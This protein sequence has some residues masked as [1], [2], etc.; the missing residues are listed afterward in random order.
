MKVIQ[1][2]EAKKPAVVEMAKPE[3]KTGEALIKVRAVGICG[4]DIT[5][6]HGTN[7]NV[8][9]Y[10][11]VIG[12]ETVG[13]IAEIPEGNEFGL[14]VGDA[15]ILDPYIYCGTCYPCS[16][17]KTNCCESMQCLGVHCEGSMSEYVAHPMKL[18]RKLPE[19]LS[20]ELAPMAEPLVIAMHS[21]HTSKVVA[22][23]KVAIIGAGTIG[24]LAAMG[25]MAYG[26]EPIVID[27]IEERLALARECGVKYTIN[28]KT[29][30][31][32]EKLM[33]I[34][35]GRGAEVVVEASGSNVGIRNTL[36]YAAYTGRVALTGWPK[37][38]TT[39]P[40]NIITKKELKVLG[41]RNGAGEF[42][43]ALELIASGKVDAGKLITKT[44]AF[45]DLPSYIEKIAQN[46]SDFL[47]VIGSLGE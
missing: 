23:E 31:D 45:E 3:A 5:T 4:T 15:V 12:H 44:V 41:S 22:G 16:Q 43:E 25:A 8:K 32:V 10:P 17:G 33:E 2:Q 6:Y 37:Q 24:L 47:K 40:T 36:D 1:M 27:V 30:N 11:I 39:L 42:E 7:V 35:E 9:A 46:P 19:N 26:A 13:T 20:L 34:T 21:L 18:L 38:E 14:K 29:E 28:P